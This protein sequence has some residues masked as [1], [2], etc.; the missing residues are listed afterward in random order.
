MASAILKEEQVE[1]L[2]KL[3]KSSC[4]DPL[5][6]HVVDVVGKPEVLSKT[7]DLM[8]ASNSPPGLLIMFNTG[9]M[10]ESKE[11]GQW[12]NYRLVKRKGTG[13]ENIVAQ[14]QFSLKVDEFQ[15]R[16]S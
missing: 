8:T 9:E 4:W 16:T 11:N 15:G 13:G 7:V 3:R 14:V 10:M 2:K 12:P 5:S 6:I 1:A